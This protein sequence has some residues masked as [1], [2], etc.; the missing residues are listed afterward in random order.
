MEGGPKMIGDEEI[1]IIPCEGRPTWFK[2]QMPLVD[3]YP[4]T[5]LPSNVPAVNVQMPEVPRSLSWA[6]VP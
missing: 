6:R 5:Q 4:R 3:V 2:T 1:F